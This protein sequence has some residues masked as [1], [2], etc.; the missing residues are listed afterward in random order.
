M[1]SKSQLKLINSLGQKKFRQKHQLFVVEGKKA[2]AELLGS[3]L[4]LH[5][6]FTTEEIFEAETEK[7]FLVSEKELKKMSRLTT[8]Q[9]AVAVFHIPEVQPLDT[10]QLILALDNVQDPGNLGTII[11]MCDWFGIRHLVCSE[12]T[13]DCFNPKVVQATMGSIARVNIR[14]R[15]LSDFFRN[16]GKGLPVYG[17]FLEGENVYEQHLRAE[18]ILVMGNEANGISSEV[19]SFISRKLVIP[20]FGINQETESLNVATA[21]AIFL[22]EFKR[23]SF[24]GK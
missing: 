20:Q 22:S 9:T 4:K 6:L 10:D 11:R 2:I 14:Y 12:G 3:A 23:G 5:S 8:P 21:T 17:A 15:V 1:F 19:E 24:T 18:G 13:V 16:E 7:T